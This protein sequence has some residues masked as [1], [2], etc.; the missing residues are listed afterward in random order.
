MG[1]ED[2]EIEVLDGFPDG[3]HVLLKRDSLGP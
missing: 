1:F 3:L 2:Y